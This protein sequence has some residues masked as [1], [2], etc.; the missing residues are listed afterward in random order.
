LSG[1][2]RTRRSEADPEGAITVSGEVAR[3]RARILVVDD[4][5]LIL[6][7]LRRILGRRYHVEC[8]TSAAEALALVDAGTHFDAILTDLAMPDM[9]G[10]ELAAKLT[11]RAP[12][13]LGRVVFMTGGPTSDEHARLLEGP[14]VRRLE[15]PFQ[16]ETLHA[17]VESLVAER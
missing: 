14:G 16:L 13:L 9:D 7:S 4:D 2:D 1:D 12:A 5:E 17:L 8:V 3:E 11:A 15:K 10:P 6:R